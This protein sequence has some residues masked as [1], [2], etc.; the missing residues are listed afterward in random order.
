MADKRGDMASRVVGGLA[1]VAA[2]FATR[3][4]LTFAWKRVIGREP[5]AHP[6]DPDVALTEAV[7]WSAVMGVAMATARMLAT[8]TATRRLRESVC[9]TPGEDG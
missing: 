7:G 6:E 9:E 3:K 2:G 4:V 8:R 1:A 5:P